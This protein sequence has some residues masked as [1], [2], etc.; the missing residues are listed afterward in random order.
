MER[1]QKKK[2]NKEDHKEI[3]RTAG[4]IKKGVKIFSAVLVVGTVGKD[5]GKDIANMAKSVILKR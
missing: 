2:P 4:G 5:H 1:F 3:N